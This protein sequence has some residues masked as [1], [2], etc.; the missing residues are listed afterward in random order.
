MNIPKKFLAVLL[1]I[2]LTFSAS[3]CVY[4]VVGGVGALGGYVV[5]PDTVEGL[6]GEREQEEVWDAAEEV[7][8]VMGIIS[9]KQ[10]ARRNK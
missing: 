5:S 8:S 3:S 9:E 10:E 1:L 4:L 2:G 7:V 6:L